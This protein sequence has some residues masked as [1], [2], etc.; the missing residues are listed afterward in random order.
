M[1]K[2]VGALYNHNQLGVPVEGEQI[3]ATA[4]FFPVSVLLRDY[5]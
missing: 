2:E 4:A 1:S 5:Q 3:D